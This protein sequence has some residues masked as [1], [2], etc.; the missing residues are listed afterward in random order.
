[1][2]ERYEFTRIMVKENTGMRPGFVKLAEICFTNGCSPFLGGLLILLCLTNNNILAQGRLE[3]TVKD[4]ASVCGT[5]R[6]ALYNRA[7]LFMKEHYQ[8]RQVRVTGTT[9]TILFDNLPAGE[10]A[11]SIFQD[12]NDNG[13]LDTN[14]F[15]IPR[16]PWGFSN[17]ARGRFGPPDFEATRFMVSG[18]KEMT[19]LLNR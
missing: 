17:N 4:V 2:I 7:D 16:E 13:V 10:Y 18:T 15:G 11:F 8:I 3:I 14:L 12:V 9:V 1:M 19:V 6:V 5:M